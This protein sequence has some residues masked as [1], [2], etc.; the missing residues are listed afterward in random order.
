MPDGSDVMVDVAEG[1]S[2]VPLVDE[3]FNVPLVDSV[4]ELSKDETDDVFEIVEDGMLRAVDVDE[5]VSM[6]E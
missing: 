3:S 2:V 5:D 4:E 6:N 1:G